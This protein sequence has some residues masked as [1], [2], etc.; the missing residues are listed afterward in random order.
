MGLSEVLL[1]Y[2]RRS[3]LT[4]LCVKWFYLILLRLVAHFTEPIL[5]IFLKTLY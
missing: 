3:T 5:A 4:Y 1:A 2:V